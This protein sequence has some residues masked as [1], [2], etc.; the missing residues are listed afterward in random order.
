MLVIFVRTI[1]LYI[2]LL[3]VMRLMGKRQ[4]G[5]MQPFEFIITL[6]IAE[7]VCI[8]MTDV[9]I[10]LSYGIVSVIAVFILHQIMSILEGLGDKIKFVISGRPSIVITPDGVVL[11]ELKKNNMGVS[12][13]IEALRNLGYFSFEDV[14]YAI[15][16][17]NGKLSALKSKN[18]SSQTLPLLLISDGKIQKNNFELREVSFNELNEKLN[19]K[20][21]K[22]K[23]VEAL[24]MDENGRVYLKLR[25]KKFEILQYERGTKEC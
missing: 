8:P 2:V 9:S 5:E 16:E 22:L 21:K 25:G 4:I 24:T 6:L 1:I 14:D 10:P 7:L 11:E 23:N 18:T 17:S 20:L 13:L 19:N 15:F 12:D 3:I